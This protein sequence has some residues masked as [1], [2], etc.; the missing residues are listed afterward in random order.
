ME[1]WKVE[2]TAEGQTL[3][4]VKIPKGLFQED[5]LSQQLIGM[6]MMPL[7]HHLENI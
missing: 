1:N 4:K 2:L 5:L 6:A 7:N 3:A